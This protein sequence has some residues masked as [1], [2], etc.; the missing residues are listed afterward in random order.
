MLGSLLCLVVPVA[1]ARPSTP[2]PFVVV[3]AENFWGS[4]AAQLAGDRATV[5]SIIV[6]PA[7][8]PH[9]YEPTAANARAVTVYPMAI[10]NG[11]GYDKRP[12]SFSPPTPPASGSCSTSSTART[13]PRRCSR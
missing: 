7:T 5:E 12:R 1:S 4:I 8:D 13:A 6:N 9:S 3:A 2:S 10:V 11:I